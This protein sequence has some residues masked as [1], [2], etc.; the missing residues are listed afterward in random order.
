[1]YDEQDKMGIEIDSF[2]IPKPTSYE[3][4]YMNID[5]LDGVVRWTRYRKAALLRCLAEQRISIN[6]A[7]KRFSLSRE[8]IHGWAEALVGG[9]VS[10]L[11][12]RGETTRMP[13]F[14]SRWRT[15]RC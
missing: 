15:S 9:G 6:E 1:M 14:S 5:K 12:A 11:K 3:I 4:E 2:D 10:G 8:E 13:K 7:S